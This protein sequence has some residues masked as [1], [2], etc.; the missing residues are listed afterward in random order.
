[1]EAIHL[2]P[3]KVNRYYGP[4]RQNKLKALEENLD[5]EPQATSA[6]KCNN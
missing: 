3:E 4:N 6:V 2:L 5:K 1:M